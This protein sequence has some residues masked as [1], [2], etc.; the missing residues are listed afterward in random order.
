MFGHML[1]RLNQKDKT[2]DLLDYAAAYSAIPNGNDSGLWYVYKGATGG[3]RGLIEVTKYYT[4]VNDYTHQESRDLI[5]YKLNLTPKELDRFID[6]LWEIYQTTYINYYFLSQNCSSVLADLLAATLLDRDDINKHEHWFY[7]PHELLKKIIS[8]KNLLNSVYLRPSSK[9]EI[10]NALEKLNESELLEVKNFLSDKEIPADYQNTKVI[11]VLL[12]IV[13]YQHKA[14][15]NYSDKAKSFYRNLLLRRTKLPASEKKTS[16]LEEAHNRPE[17]SH[18][19][20]KLSF[21][22]RTEKSH[23]LLGLEFKNGYHN[24]MNK[25]EGFESFSQVDFLSG[26]ALYDK[27]LNR[28]SFD[29][30]MI[31]DIISLHSLKFYDPQFSWALTVKVDRDYTLNCELCH[32]INLSAKAGTSYKNSDIYTVYGML[33]LFS[34]T[35]KHLN[36]GERIGPSANFGFVYNIQSKMKVGLFDEWRLN[37]LTKNSSQNVGSV[38]INYFK[39]G[40]EDIILEYKNISTIGAKL[41]F[42]KTETTLWQLSYGRYF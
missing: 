8:E 22:T 20:M 26:S 17:N 13:T 16:P 10:E 24:I 38:K 2:N 31:V 1:I 12:D 39:S 7:M 15:H 34:E 40:N 4:K 32:K 14:D 9:K 29:E 18:D 28:L 5:E 37:L 42:L 41:D 35:S 33:G 25:D 19:P 6:H 27:K 11:D 36:R 21:F 23:S 3:Y 30:L